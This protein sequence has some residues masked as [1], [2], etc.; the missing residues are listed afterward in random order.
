MP[1]P[2]DA[3]T[4]GDVHAERNHLRDAPETIAR[5]DIAP[6]AKNR[7]TRLGE[8]RVRG[9]RRFSV[10]QKSFDHDRDLVLIRRRHQKIK[11]VSTDHLG[12]GPAENTLGAFVPVDDSPFGIPN[13][14][15]ERS[16]AQQSSTQAGHVQRRTAPTFVEPPRHR[17]RQD[18]RADSPA[19]DHRVASCRV[20]R[21]GGSADS[22]AP[23]LRARAQNHENHCRR[24]ARECPS[25]ATPL[26]S[27]SHH[28][29]QALQRATTIITDRYRRRGLHKGENLLF[30]L[31]EHP[32][33]ESR[34]NF[35][36]DLFS[37]CK[38]P[39]ADFAE[40]DCFTSVSTFRRGKI[41]I[42]LD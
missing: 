35:I 3:P 38:N 29:F 10:A 31:I 14:Q 39:P 7:F 11:R 37:Y 15:G 1:F 12:F 24:Q 6:L 21:R 20:D 9:C 16:F 18:D 4:I 40:I 8:V 19:D 23:G 42:G 28:V 33:A 5:G 17:R 30:A 13:D 36:R 25:R 32:F 27:P 34:V 41:R 26:R 2:F 22:L